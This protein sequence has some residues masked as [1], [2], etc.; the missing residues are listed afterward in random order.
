MKLWGQLD[1]KPVLVTVVGG[2]ILGAGGLVWSTVM[3]VNLLE[4]RM[5]RIED[6]QEVILGRLPPAV[7]VPTVR[8]VSG[9]RPSGF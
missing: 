5:A 8:Q 9:K 4:A 7:P 3:K 6:T 2:A 1:L